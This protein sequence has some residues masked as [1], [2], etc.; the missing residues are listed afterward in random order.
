MGRL[1]LNIEPSLREVD[2][3]FDHL[4]AVEEQGDVNPRELLAILKAASFLILYNVAESSVRA[5]VEAIC[6]A[7]E[8][9]QLSLG[10]LSERISVLLVKEQ[11]LKPLRDGAASSSGERLALALMVKAA[12]QVSLQISSE[13]L[14]ISGNIDAEKVREVARVFG[15]SI[16]APRDA[17]GGRCLLTIKTRRNN[18]AHGN[19]RFTDCG[20][21]YLVSELLDFKSQFGLY[22]RATLEGVEYYLERRMYDLAVVL[23]GVDGVGAT[24]IEVLLA[25]FGSPLAV[26]SASLVE[27]KGVHGITD[28][29]ASNIIQVSRGVRLP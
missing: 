24:E 29:V 6:Q 16:E 19:E 17:L 18:L 21:D 27:L 9:A 1:L 8:H 15:F 5:C 14:P 22:V 11:L 3:F 28:E 10:S 7:I 12:N 20:N 26:F 23:A 2:L 13:T 4:L 25:R